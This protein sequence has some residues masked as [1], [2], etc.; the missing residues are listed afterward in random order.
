MS[1]GIVRRLVIFGSPGALVVLELAHPLSATDTSATWWTTL[2]LIQMPLFGLVG[3]AAFLLVRRDGVDRWS[4]ALVATSI[5]VFV[6]YYTA[7]DAVG[8]VAL[9]RLLSFQATLPA[10]ERVIVGR[11]I[12][13]MYTRTGIVLFFDVGTW[14]WTIGLLVAALSL[15]RSGLP[16]PP[17]VILVLSTIPLHQDHGR[18]YGPIAFGLFLVAALWFELW[19]S[20]GPVVSRRPMTS[21][22]P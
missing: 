5:G 11:A 6:V 18:P 10:G 21:A 12:D 16:W 17:A 19:P 13:A 9:G 22:I 15:V 3:L 2:H 1:D 8:G 7:L 14:A 4:I 20:R